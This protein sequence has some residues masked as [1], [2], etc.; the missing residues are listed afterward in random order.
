ML[1]SARNDPHGYI[2]SLQARKVVLDEFQYAPELIPAIKEASDQ[3]PHGERGKFLLTGST[4][5][6]RSA[7]VQE[8]LPGHMARLELLPLSLSEL[9]DGQDNIVDMLLSGKFNRGKAALL[10]REQLATWILNGGYPEVQEKSARA[11]QVW[12]RSYM[13]GRLFKDFASLYAARG[14]YHS[15]IQAL[16]PYLAGLCGN[17]LKYANIGN[18]LSLDDRVVKNYIEI[19]ELMFIVR[20]VPAWLKNRGKRQATQLPKLHFVDTGL[21]CHLLGLTNAHSLL[22]SQYFG[23]LLENSL[24]MELT[25][26]SGWAQTPVTLYHFR[27][28][29][30]QEVD[31]VLERADGRLTGIEV[32]ASSTLRPGD[33]KSLAR[34]AEFAGKKFEQGVILY[35]GQEVLPFTLG[36]VSCHALPMGILKGSLP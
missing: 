31:M 32:K 24:F 3:L 13:E 22:A 5:F 19:L 9:H 28:H 33:F 12:F 10:E 2:R 27:D 25:K 11:Q 35:S 4:D 16:A 30:Q 6:F 20:R 15:K 29:R 8:A 34:L 17:L 36:E 14:D 23:G 21:A 26:Q 18:D 1:A 7:R